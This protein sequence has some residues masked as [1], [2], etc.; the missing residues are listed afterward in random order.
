MKLI[1]RALFGFFPVIPFAVMGL[2]FGILNYIAPDA[3]IT[4]T[5]LV[6]AGSF[7]V[8]VFLHAAILS[9]ER[10]WHTIEDNGGNNND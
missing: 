9:T 2:A 7:I 5:I 4:V 6:F 10:F 3:S 1:R 8:G